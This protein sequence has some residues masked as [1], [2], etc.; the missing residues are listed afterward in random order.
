M[1]KYP[2]VSA[3]GL[4]QQGS[5]KVEATLDVSV[6]T[7]PANFG[8]LGAAGG[9]QTLPH[10]GKAVFFLK[11]SQIP[12]GSETSCPQADGFDFRPPNDPSTSDQELVPYS[13]TPCDIQVSQV[14]SASTG[15]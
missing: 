3:Y 10:N 8:Q 14:F 15:S 9:L 5:T 11:W 4:L 1:N 2:F 12:T 7:I 6:G 13:F